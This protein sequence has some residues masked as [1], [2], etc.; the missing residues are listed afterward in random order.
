MIETENFEAGMSECC[1]ETIQKFKEK[2]GI[3]PKEKAF[4]FCRSRI[5][6]NYLAFI[7]GT[8]TFNDKIPIATVS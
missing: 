5:C 6:G 2:F 8:W 3:D 7:D 1:K 4:I